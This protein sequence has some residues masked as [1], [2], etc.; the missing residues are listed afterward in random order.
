MGVGLVREHL[1]VRGQV[2]VSK[3]VQISELWKDLGHEGLGRPS[4]EKCLPGL[5]E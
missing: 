3:E 2:D 5:T 4:E 1:I